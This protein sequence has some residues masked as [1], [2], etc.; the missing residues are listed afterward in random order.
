MNAEKILVPLAEGFE[1]VEALAIVDVLRRADLDVITAS[2]ADVRVPGAHGV[3][4]E[5][6]APL[7]D[8]DL[9]SITAVVRPGGMPGSTNLAADPRYARV[10]RRLKKHI[11]SRPS[12][13]APTSMKLMPHHCP[14]FRSR[15][16]YF[17]WLNNGKDY[18][19]LIEKYWP[20]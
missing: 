14:P 11:P 1:E 15:Q 6:D 8:V 20:H 3:T 19:Y 4:V 10:K 5:A 16:E 18:G 2:L 9:A 17:D 12:P 7:D 13:L